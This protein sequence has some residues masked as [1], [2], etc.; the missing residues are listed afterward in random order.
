MPRYYFRLVSPTH[1]V[2]DE[3]GLELEDLAA[4]HWSA[5]RLIHRIAIVL[6]EVR[7]G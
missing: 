3:E 5:L 1:V 7:T 2:A 6:N 4:A